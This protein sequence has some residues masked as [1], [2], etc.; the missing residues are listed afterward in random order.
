[1]SKG[2]TST[3]SVTIHAP[4]A[5]VWDALTTPATIKRYMF[6]TDAV[7]EWKEGSPIVWKGEYE[8]RAYEDKGL[9]LTLQPG[10]LLRYSHF[11]PLSGQPDVPE[12]YHT[13][14]VELW[15]HG[16]E[17]ELRLTQD[18][19]PTEEARDHTAQAWQGML[20]R[21]KEVLEE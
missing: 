5:A 6:D 8:G 16:D 3:A 18:N 19:N 17:T 13:V 2:L 21:L 20:E 1:M 11:S 4:A 7:S 15:E 9:I 12:N 10:R 14:T